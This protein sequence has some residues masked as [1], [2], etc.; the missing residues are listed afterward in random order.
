VHKID[1]FYIDCRFW[2]MMGLLSIS[3]KLKLFH[4]MDKE[5]EVEAAVTRVT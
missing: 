4:R 2:V 5:F 3:D 1:A